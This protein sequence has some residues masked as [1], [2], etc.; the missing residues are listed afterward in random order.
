MD[1][2]HQLRGPYLTDLVAE[3]VS[4]A[5]VAVG[6]AGRL[7]LAE[8][9][10]PG[11][12]TVFSA[13]GAC[14]ST[15][16]WSHVETETLACTALSSLVVAGAEVWALAAPCLREGPG[17][18]IFRWRLDDCGSLGTLDVDG[19]FPVSMALP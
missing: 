2:L 9:L 4:L 18:R 5:D 8:H 19:Y 6:P 17:T 10:Y 16:D 13:R 14:A 11:M 3:T 1:E 15:S 12:G 7:A